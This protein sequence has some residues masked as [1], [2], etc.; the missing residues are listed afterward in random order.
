MPQALQGMLYSD[1]LAGWRAVF[2][3]STCCQNL[4][5]LATSQLS[6]HSSSCWCHLCHVHM[7]MFQRILDN[8]E[9]GYWFGRT[10]NTTSKKL[11]YQNQEQIHN[12]Q[13]V[14][15]C[16]YASLVTDKKKTMS[17]RQTYCHLYH[18]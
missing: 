5:V 6:L 15:F 10:E 14:T 9:Y 13:E 1:P 3:L 11:C 8:Q 18:P 17:F 12:R 4:T 2:I 7:A 16:F